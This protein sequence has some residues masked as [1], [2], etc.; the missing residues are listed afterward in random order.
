MCCQQLKNK[1]QDAKQE[2]TMDERC[3]HSAEPSTEDGCER[4]EVRGLQGQ[5]AF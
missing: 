4:G 5:C 2:S 3:F 1:A